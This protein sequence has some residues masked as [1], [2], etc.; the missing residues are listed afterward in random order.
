MEMQDGHSFTVTNLGALG[1]TYFTPIINPP[2]A[3][4]LAVGKIEDK[5]VVSEDGKLTAKKVGRLTL[6]FDHRLIDG[7][8]AARFLKTLRE[9]LE[10][11]E[12]LEK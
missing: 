1:V 10:N 3:A 12:H 4:I 6:V 11:P 5:P 7:A 9:L 8:P 2:D